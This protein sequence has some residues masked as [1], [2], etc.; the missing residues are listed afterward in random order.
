[1]QAS[2][3]MD[4]SDFGIPRGHKAG[5][6]NDN[7]IPAHGMPIPLI[8]NSIPLSDKAIPHNDTP[9][10]AN[11]NSIPV[12]GNLIPAKGSGASHQLPRSRLKE[13]HPLGDNDS[14]YGESGETM[15]PGLRRRVCREHSR[16]TGDLLHFSG[17]NRNNREDSRQKEI[18]E[19]TLGS[20]FSR[21]AWFGRN[22]VHRHFICTK[23]LI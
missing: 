13:A 3:L 21:A 9:I 2:E 8:G 10:P 6:S 18:S 22:S 16:P 11:D 23:Q 12:S 15:S 5:A 19:P 17:K 20:A 4:R 7:A 1:M 14:K